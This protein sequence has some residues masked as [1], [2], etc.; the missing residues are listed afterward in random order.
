MP[1][2]RSLPDQISIVHTRDLIGVVVQSSGESNGGGD[3]CTTCAKSN[4]GQFQECI[5]VKVC[6]H[7][8]CG[9][10]HF[11]QKTSRQA[12]KEIWG[13]SLASICT[14][15]VITLTSSDWI[16]IQPQTNTG[17]PEVVRQSESFMPSQLQA[18][19]ISKYSRDG[20]WPPGYQV[21]TNRYHFPDLWQT[22][23]TWHTLSEF[24]PKSGRVGSNQNTYRI[25]LGQVL[26]IAL[27][28]FASHRGSGKPRT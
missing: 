28:D 14:F 2:K 1:I 15:H 23:S 11:L 12:G 8:R 17:M 25:H 27:N 10:C 4:I 26:S 13:C 19:L 6:A 24:K 7:G 18:A 16:D 9:N 3:A 22:I 21:L 5:A 20:N